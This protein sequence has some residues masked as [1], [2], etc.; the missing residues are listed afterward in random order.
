MVTLCGLLFTV[1]YFILYQSRSSGLFLISEWFY[2]KR[3]GSQPDINIICVSP[4]E[5]SALLLVASVR[6]KVNE[7]QLSTVITLNTSKNVSVG[8]E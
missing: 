1:M 7:S 2:N 4:K 6:F 8:L 5:C 3:T